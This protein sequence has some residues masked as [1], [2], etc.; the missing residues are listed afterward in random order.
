MLLPSLLFAALLAILIKKLRPRRLRLNGYII[1]LEIQNINSIT[2]RKIYW[3]VFVFLICFPKFGSMLFHWRLK[4][5]PSLNIRVLRSFLVI[6]LSKKKKETLY[7]MDVAVYSERNSSRIFNELLKRVCVT[8]VF[9]LDNSC[10]CDVL[11]KAVVGIYFWVIKTKKNHRIRFR[12]YTI[13]LV[14]FYSRA[15]LLAWLKL[16]IRSVLYITCSYKIYSGLK[17]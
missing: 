5:S 3:C 8:L 12:S 2:K 4:N 17:R 14:I 6:I 1:I 16:F 10:E 9:G 15:L 11:S 7:D 13:A